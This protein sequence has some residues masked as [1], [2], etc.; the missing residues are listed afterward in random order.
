PSTKLVE[1]NVLKAN[2]EKLAA[3]EGLNLA[4]STLLSEADKI[5]T[6][7]I[8]TVTE[9]KQLP[10]SGD[11]HDYYSLALYWWPNPKGSDDSP[12]IQIDGKRNPERETIPDAKALSSNARDVY[13]LG[14]AYFYSQEEKYA[15]HASDILYKFFIDEETKMSPNLDFGQMIKGHKPRPR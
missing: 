15:K 12:Y 11:I 1:G 3:N 8:L 10:P 7:P 14:L 9:K 6:Q 5:L 4:V 13:I 2:K